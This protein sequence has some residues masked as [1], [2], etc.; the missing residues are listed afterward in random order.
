MDGTN[1]N[2]SRY[3]ELLKAFGRVV[4]ERDYLRLQH[5]QESG[6]LD[7]LQGRYN[8]LL[9]Q[10]SSLTADRDRLAIEAARSAAALAA[11]ETAR[12]QSEATVETWRNRFQEQ[13][14]SYQMAE[15][16]RGLAQWQRRQELAAISSALGLQVVGGNMRN[17]YHV[18]LPTKLGAQ[19]IINLQ[20]AAF[21]P[22]PSSY[23]FAYAKAGSVMLDNIIEE[24]A[25]T[26][27]L[28][29]FNLN[30]QLFT[31]GHSP[32]D[33]D[34]DL[35]RLFLPNGCIH[36]GF[37]NYPDFQ[38]P[39]LPA[40]RCALMVRDPR[41]MLVSMYYSWTQS[42]HVPHGGPQRDY[43]LDLREKSQKMDIDEFCRANSFGYMYALDFNNKNGLDKAITLRYEDYIFN[44]PALVERLCVIFGTEL[45]SNEIRR[46]AEKFDI[47]PET[48]DPASHIRNVKTGNF[49]DKLS[50]ETIAILNRELKPFLDF[51]GY[52]V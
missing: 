35:R 18:V 13:Q 44:K 28:P 9:S 40:N 11:A 1:E 48:E 12:Q 33:I 14:T 31:Q 43:M 27:G 45:P 36:Y 10:L 52:E 32:E 2:D 22:E 7:G 5:E 20:V 49:R 3:N 39:V 4:A 25:R 50:T 38:L 8:Q 29:A 24:L 23:V 21:A 17:G 6:Q 30:S 16:D 51:Y 46:I 26:A 37:R 41:D 47:R 34:L 42:H 19:C 15:S